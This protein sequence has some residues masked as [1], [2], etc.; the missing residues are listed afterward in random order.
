MKDTKNL[1]ERFKNRGKN[2]YVSS[3]Q[4]PMGV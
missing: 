1:S 3:L 4:K 2:N